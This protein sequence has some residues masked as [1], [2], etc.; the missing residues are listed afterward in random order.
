VDLGFTEVYNY[1]FLSEDRVTRF[2]LRAEDQVRVLNPIASDQALMR[3]TL[4]PG[5]W[6]NILENSKHR[7]AFRLF[8]VGLEIHK[9]YEGLPD[10]IPHAVAAVYARSGDGTAGLFELK[11]AALCLLPRLAVEP[12]EAA[13]YEHP[14]RSANL[15]A[16]GEL[17][18]RLF[19]LHPG[20]VETGRAAVLDMNVRKLQALSAAPVKYVPVRRYPASAFDLSVIAGERVHAGALQTAIAGFG[21]SLVEAVEFVRQYTGAQLSQGQKS[22]SFRLT[23]G[24]P[25]RTLTSEEVGEIRTRVIEGMRGLGYELRV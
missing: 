12:A 11:H 20:L 3:S 1:S 10:E 7:E 21:G 17:V 13:D 4:L 9:K 2:G 15:M 23:V 14:A 24:S 6:S 8:E 18:G 5:L 16:E 19:E 25:E 22:V